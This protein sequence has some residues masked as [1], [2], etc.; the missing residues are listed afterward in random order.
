MFQL[1]RQKLPAVPGKKS[2]VREAKGTVAWGEREREECF[3]GKSRMNR[4]DD[5]ADAGTW[6]GG[7]GSENRRRN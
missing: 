6:D 1:S 2:E 5:A 7:L 4:Q 3:C